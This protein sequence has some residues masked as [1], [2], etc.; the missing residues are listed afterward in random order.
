MTVR[1]LVVLG[2][3]SHSPTRER[4]HNGYLLR[5]DG[6]GILFDPGEGTQRQMSFAEVSPA[7]IHRICITHFHGDHCFGLPGVLM[8]LSQDQITH[9]IDIHYPAAGQVNL[10]RLRHASVGFD[11]VDLWEQPITG[12]GVIATT[13]TYTLTALPL[14]HTTHTFGY[15]LEE[16]PGRRMLPDR[17]DALGITG[18]DVGDLIEH[19]RL[20]LPDGRTVT[21]EE[22]SE[23]RD[24]Q[25]V[26]YLLDTAWC[27]EALE[28]ARGADLLI[29][30]ATF[31]DEHAEM[32]ERFGHLTA[33]QA[34]RLATEAGA[35]RLVLT[36]FSQ[37]YRD[38]SAFLA[39]AAEEHADV[40]LANDLDRIPVPPRR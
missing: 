18:P 3:S 16:P 11:T 21:H 33:R 19:G 25:V 13:D 1:E 6:D 10:E 12:P 38:E 29:C 14:R 7:V 5:W 27:D 34:G 24:G 15:R 2:T 36:H 8:R 31:C 32:A 40:V 28:L 20:R 23:E 35:R 17:L 30:E 26:A 37:R 9:R 22:V 4:N 39:E